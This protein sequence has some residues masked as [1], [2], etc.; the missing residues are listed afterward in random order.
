MALSSWGLIFVLATVLKGG[1]HMFGGIDYPEIIVFWAPIVGMG[2]P[3]AINFLKKKS[4]QLVLGIFAVNPIV[5]VADCI[6]G[7]FPHC[8]WGRSI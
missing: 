6:F 8:Y 3:Y 4:F 1:V 7:F 2:L 5:G